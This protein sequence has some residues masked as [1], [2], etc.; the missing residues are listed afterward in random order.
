MAP[1]SVHLKLTTPIAPLL[2]NMTALKG[3]SR[4]FKM[5]PKKIVSKI[6]LNPSRHLQ[7]MRAVMSNEKPKRAT[8]ARLTQSWQNG[9][10]NSD[11]DTEDR[12]DDRDA[13]PSRAQQSSTRGVVTGRQQRL[14]AQEIST[15]QVQH[16]T[17][18]SSATAPSQPN[19]APQVSR[20]T[21]DVT[22]THVT[23][24]VIQAEASALTQQTQ[25]GPQTFNVAIEP[26]AH[27]P[28][29]PVSLSG[30][31]QAENPPNDYL[32]STPDVLQRIVQ[33][34]ESLHVG[35]E[36]LKN[37]LQRLENGFDSTALQL[38]GSRFS[39]LFDGRRNRAC[40]VRTRK[41]ASLLSP[42]LPL[43]STKLIGF[44]KI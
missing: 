10:M 5:A 28:G 37:R 43:K 20:E 21:V 34:T 22:P 4:M 36:Q 9:G 32:G 7:A 23:V 19:S 35:V 16:P 13:G 26:S 15:A 3:R 1:Q 41:I 17:S 24:N 8:A 30:G 40:R 44:K 25:P 31:P 39:H 14:P 6:V 29:V 27:A 2:F 11:A 42:S 38:E 18:P 33:N 12:D